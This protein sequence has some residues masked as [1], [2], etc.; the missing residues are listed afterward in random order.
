M[1][2]ESNKYKVATW[3]L[4]IIVVVLLVMISMKNQETVGDTLEGLSDDVQDC[5]M[6]LTV[7]NETYP[8]GTTTPQSQTELDAI[9]EDCSDVIE[10]ASEEL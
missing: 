3:I 9:L 7:W 4:A 10:G 6:R 1:Q 2:P 5:R 8:Q